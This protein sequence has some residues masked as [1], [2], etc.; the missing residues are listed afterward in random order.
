[1][2]RFLSLPAVLSALSHSRVADF[3]GIN[4]QEFRP[5]T[6]WFRKLLSWHFCPPE[7]IIVRTHNRSTKNRLK[8]DE[9]MQK[10]ADRA[11]DVRRDIRVIEREKR[12]VLVRDNPG[13]T[14]EEIEARL[15]RIME[16]GLRQT[17]AL[18]RR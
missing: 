7:I 6:P 12:A 1:M 13:A 10:R 16:R 2:D 15:R 3:G 14:P 11:D 8:F 17:P 18:P 9:A 4:A 5:A